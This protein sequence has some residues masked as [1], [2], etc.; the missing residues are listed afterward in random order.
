MPWPHVPGFIN[1]INPLGVCSSLMVKDFPEAFLSVNWQIFPAKETADYHGG[2]PTRA[3]LTGTYQMKYVAIPL[4]SAIHHSATRCPSTVSSAY[5]GCR[6]FHF[7]RGGWNRPKAVNKNFAICPSFSRLTALRSEV[8]HSFHVPIMAPFISITVASISSL[9]TT[10]A[11]VSQSYSSLWRFCL[12]FV[13][14]SV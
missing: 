5:V 7:H 2:S 12:C 13:R 1:K 9:F 3:M 4:T 6:H 10:L 11:T 8:S 14:S